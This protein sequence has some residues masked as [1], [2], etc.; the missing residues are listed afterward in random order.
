MGTTPVTQGQWEAVMLKNPSY[1]KDGKVFKFGFMK[2]KTRP[3]CPVESVSWKDCQIFIDRLNRSSQGYDY[4]LATEAQW[5]YAAR[6]GSTGKYCFG[7]T[8]SQVLDSFCWYTAN[9][10]NETHPVAQ[11]D[12]NLWGLYD[13]HGNVWEWCGDGYD[14]DYYH[15]SPEEDPPGHSTDK[16][17]VIRG[18]SWDTSSMNCSLDIRNSRP[19]EYGST[20]CGLRV[21]SFKKIPERV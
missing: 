5:E 16:F 13:V 19:P 8:Y 2:K 11:K 4:R 10:Y 20:V 7:D 3:M 6:A 12:H 17:K 1:Y 14:A 9:S 15:H 18:G 21:V